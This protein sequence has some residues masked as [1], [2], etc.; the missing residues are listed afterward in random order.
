MRRAAQP[1]VPTLP[2]SDLESVKTLP[3]SALTS[4]SVGIRKEVVAAPA[5]SA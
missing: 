2:F 5:T 3:G 1:T 4:D